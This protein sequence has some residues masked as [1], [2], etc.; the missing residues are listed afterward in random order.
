LASAIRYN[1][2][3]LT[4]FERDALH[5]ET[6]R[7]QGSLAQHRAYDAL[8]RRHWLSTT[9][10]EHG[11]VTLPEQG[12]LWRIYQY[13]GR[14]ELEQVRDALRGQ[15]D[16][17]Y[18]REGRLLQHRERHSGLRSPLLNYDQAD[19]LLPED[20]S[21]NAWHSNRLLSWDNLF[22]R[23]DDWGN[24]IQR[25]QGQ[26][27]QHFE[28]DADNRLIAA[29]GYG[30]QGRYR[31]RYHYDALGRRIS[32]Q[33]ETYPHSPEEPVIETTRFV[34]QG[35]R[36]L[37]Q[38]NDDN[39]RST[40]C[41]DPKDSWSPLARCD[42]SEHNPKAT[43]YWFTSDL[44]GAPLEVSN[45]QGKLV[46]SG[47][48][49]LFGEVKRQTTESFLR[50]LR[51]ETIDQPLRYAGQFA[52]NETGLHYNL[53][54]YYDPQ[55]G[56]FT[57]QDPIGLRGGLNLY[58]YAPNPL[59]WI[60]PLGLAKGCAGGSPK[61]AQRKIDKRQGPKDIKRIDEPE[62]NSV[63]GS[64]WHAHQTQQVKGKNPAL[65]QDGSTH[66]GTPSFSKKTLQW[67]QD[68]GWNVDDLL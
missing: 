46:W 65:N 7:T 54:R 68:H 27:Q 45:D 59:S 2:Q 17:Q 42:Q 3:T 14:G 67:L 6:R 58:S 60:D 47:H 11:Q 50:D 20:N 5:R 48:Y 19:N 12:I 28:Y 18:D 66:D 15:I 64:Q 61:D 25:T 41:Y 40:Y 39:S 32:K 49:Q 63:P 29:H 36:L 55:V 62:P 37:Q 51:T 13:S 53:F 34:W 22:N 21:Q 10:I 56:R 44:N 26:H 23:Y 52:D 57:T 43:L 30:P 8:G 4:E 35:Y 33:V 1:Q 16:F 38:L 9:A 31:A 24:L